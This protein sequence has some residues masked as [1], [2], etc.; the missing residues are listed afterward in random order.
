[1]VPF[2]EL[3]LLLETSMWS[4]IPSAVISS[5]PD[6]GQGGIGP[7]LVKVIT[8]MANNFRANKVGIFS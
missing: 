2:G 7:L 4:P 6:I 1:M 3:Y 8:S 5:F